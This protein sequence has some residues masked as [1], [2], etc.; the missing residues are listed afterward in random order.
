[1]KN[2]KDSKNTYRIREKSFGDDPEE[3]YKLRGYC[4]QKRR[5]EAKKAKLTEALLSGGGLQQIIDIGYQVLG[6]P[7]FVSD[8]GYNVLAF[9]KNAVVGDPSWPA[10]KSEEEF[11]AYERIKK[12]NDSGVFERL[13][14]SESPC[15]EHFDYAPTR[16]MATKIA[17]NGD[18]IGHVAVVESN[19]VF[20][21]M[22]FEL[23]QWL[24]RI[25][26]NELQKEPI[27][28][29]QLAGEFEHFLVG[30]LEEKIIKAETIKKQGNKLGLKAK[31]YCC[32][33]TVSPELN[34]AKRMS[35]SYI[36]SIINRILGTE[37]SILYQNKI[38]V[39]LLCD[40][41]E[42]LSAT[43]KSKLTEFLTSNQMNAGVSACFSELAGLKDHYNQSIKA[44]ELGVAINPKQKLFYYDAYAFYYL[45]EMAGDQNRLKD[46][47]SGALTDLMDY[48]QKYQTNYCHN[49]IIHL[50]ND[51]NVTKTAQY[52]QIHRNS[53][54][55]RIKK[56]EEI[57]A[58][59]LA[60]SEI[61]FS[62]MMSF[63]LLTYLGDELLLKV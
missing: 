8:M 40:R 19:K 23:L 16:W 53:M 56:I 22:D 9:N 35:L 1:M 12:L 30:M 49:L 37:K 43:A 11:A 34:T 61:K 2:S 45:L 54:K 3:N 25:V 55:Y 36:R 18:N 10:A 6:N 57:M 58:V 21:Q 29:G 27:R 63:K 15:I 20:T 13:Y 33:V 24:S 32:L 60:D 52:F 47:C 48:D 31:K 17:I 5:F 59:S 38:T 62:L 50:Q 28:S 41:K 7:M 39:L 42:A 46:F 44:L 14:S 26:A 51:G 4:L